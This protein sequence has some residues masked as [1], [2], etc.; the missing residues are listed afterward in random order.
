V[1]IRS[2]KRLVHVDL[3]DQL[4]WRGDEASYHQS[5]KRAVMVEGRV[6]VLLDPRREKW[7]GGGD[8]LNGAMREERKGGLATS[9][10]GWG[11]APAAAQTRQRWGGRVAHGMGSRARRGWYGELL[12]GPIEREKGVRPVW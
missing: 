2:S 6:C 4:G 1:L 9:V 12:R 11:L 10:D 7:R 8:R 5:S 3:T